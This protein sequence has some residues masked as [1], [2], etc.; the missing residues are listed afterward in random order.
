[1]NKAKPSK[2]KTSRPSA[3]A[4]SKR[5]E[6]R[7]RL[8]VAQER[9]KDL[10]RKETAERE[11]ANRQLRKDGLPTPW[12]KAEIER[13]ERRR[14]DPIIIERHKRHEENRSAA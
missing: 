8:Y 4:S 14:V 13:R 3:S 12:E 9:T 7:K 10:R 6:R 5:N 1:M 11:V 2:K